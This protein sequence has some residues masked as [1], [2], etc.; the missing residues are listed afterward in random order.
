MKINNLSIPTDYINTLVIPK[1]GNEYVF[2]AKPVVDYSVFEE[3]CPK[4][5][6]RM[7]TFPGGV[8]KPVETKDF[9]AE[10]QAWFLKRYHWMMIE[11]LSATEGL[12]WD[13]VN[14]DDPESWALWEKDL[15][16]SG[17]SGLEISLILDL[18]HDACGINSEKIEKA[19]KSFLQKQELG[20]EE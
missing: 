2:K 3:T 7:G 17:F 10:E 8:K 12:E 15:Q 16:A 6:R 1:A 4:P 11:S 13:S 19:T 20:Q 18:V 14:P 9:V 5:E